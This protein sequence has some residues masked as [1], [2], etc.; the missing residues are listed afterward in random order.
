[1]RL[2]SK[3]RYTRAKKPSPLGKGDR[4]AVDEVSH[5]LRPHPTVLDRKHATDMFTPFPLGKAFCGSTAPVPY[6]FAWK[7]LLKSPVC[8][9]TTTS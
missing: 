9:F 6:C 3:N 1:M 8:L 5:A 7:N 2:N 4:E